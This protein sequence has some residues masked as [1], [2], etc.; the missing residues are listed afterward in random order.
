[1]LRNEEGMLQLINLAI[2]AV[3]MGS[4]GTSDTAVVA[5]VAMACED[6]HAV[7]SPLVSTDEATDSAQLH[8]S[9]QEEC[10]ELIGAAKARC[11]LACGI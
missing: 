9:C 7:T 4:S 5:D 2:F 10:L 11:I 6:G 3:F 8:D 1:M